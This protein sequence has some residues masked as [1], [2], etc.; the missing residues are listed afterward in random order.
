M[1]IFTVEG[2]PI[3][4]QSYR[5]VKGG[6]YTDPRV[7]SWQNTV[8]WKAKEAMIGKDI[9]TCNLFV[10]IYFYRSDKRRVDLDN[11]SKAV[12]DA[13]N[14]IIWEDDKQVIALKLYKMYD[15]K[16]PRIDMYVRGL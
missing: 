1:I 8:A 6:G 15:K 7:K 2:N 11:L 14:N 12:L 10:E 4:K 3:P 5:A 16:N 13:C 9:I